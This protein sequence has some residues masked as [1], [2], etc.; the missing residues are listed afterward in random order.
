LILGIVVSV[1]G[2]AGIAFVLYVLRELGKSRDAGASGSTAARPERE[3][4]P[5]SPVVALPETTPAAEAALSGL[6]PH[7]ITVILAVDAA[8]KAG[9]RRLLVVMPEGVGRIGTMIAVLRR[10][11][12]EGRFTRMLFLVNTAAGAR[13][14]LERL[15]DLKLENS[16]SRG[17]RV[18]PMRSMRHELRRRRQTDPNPAEHYDCVLLEDCRS[19]LAEGLLSILL[20]E[21]NPV[22]I[23]LTASSAPSTLLT[24]GEPVAAYSYTNAV[25]DGVLVGNTLHRIQI[26]YHDGS[27]SLG[28]LA[29]PAWSSEEWMQCVCDYLAEHLDPTAPGKTL[30]FATDT[31]HAHGIVKALNYAMAVRFGPD[32]D[33]LAAAITSEADRSRNTLWQ[34]RNADRPKIAVT[35]NLSA[36]NIYTPEIF[37]LVLLR[38]VRSPEL[39]EQM[40]AQAS[41][42][43]PGKHTLRIYDAVGLDLHTLTGG[44]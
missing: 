28:S 10:S 15:R 9:Q 35:A 12:A 6:R 40:V 41:V 5:C 27:G 14:I 22:V 31:V 21:S 44:L 3:R 13:Q 29:R 20:R 43:S 38:P 1:T 26:V 34:F 16:A 19:D 33:D 25:E 39:F 32:H 36:G 23:G 8:L 2:I 11:F 4:L 24:F 37:N 17:L 30:I 7:Q 18:A 42:V